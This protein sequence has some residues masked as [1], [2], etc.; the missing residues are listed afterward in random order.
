LVSTNIYTQSYQN[1]TNG[2]FESQVSEFT[3]VFFRLMSKRIF[4]LIK[5][6]LYLRLHSTM[7]RIPAGNIY[8]IVANCI[9]V[10]SL[11]ENK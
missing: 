5:F 2:G 1:I 9:G 11:S 4:A 6:S 8:L 3:K 7:A 10:F